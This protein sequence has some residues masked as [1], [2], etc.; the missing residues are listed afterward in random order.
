[1]RGPE[2]HLSSTEDATRTVSSGRRA[3][4]RGMK[5]VSC[6]I[7]MLHILVISPLAGAAETANCHVGIYRLSDGT[8]VDIGHSD[9]D[10]LR[11]RRFDGATGHLTRV[12]DGPWKSTL[13][14]TAR[15]DDKGV[16]LSGC[17]EGRISFEGLQGHRLGLD[18]RETTFTSHGVTLAGRLLLPKGATTVPIVVLVHGAEHESARDFNPLQ[19]ILPAEGVGS[20][21]YDKRGTGASGGDYSQDFNLLA[22][23][24]VAA[25]REA[26]RLAGSR[27]GRI[28][29]QGGS[30]A[31][32]VIPIAVNRERVDFAIVCFGLAV[33]VIDE[34]QQEVQIEMRE[35]GHSP[36]E[37]A[38]ALQVASAAETVIASGFTRGFREFDAIR[39]LYKDAPWYKD[40]HGNYTYMLLPYSEAELR[41]MAPKFAW[42]TPFYYDPM[43]A[44]R[45]DTTSQLWI[46]G[47]E[48]YEAPSL[49]T[50]YRIKSLIADGRPFTLA[51]YPGAEHGMTLFETDPA[52]GERLS[53]RYAPR[54]FA[55]IRDYARN[56]RLHGAYG[57]AE[58]TRPRG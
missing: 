57:D 26:K 2:P 34:D 44:L 23:D 4:A 56:G 58:L 33:S 32:W 18:V 8:T 54:Y 53:T 40:L 30:Q 45:S 24:L 41:A 51:V 28:G 9:D 22:D 16:G 19:R 13:G 37:V 39:A 25:M 52:S 35:K 15:P 47:T 17:A 42:G 12:G 6:S 3:R 43:P 11:W 36:M 50:S 46:L 27:A 29:Y 7:A 38:S 14:W 20:F 48:D 49:E 21:V 1:M 10:T 55:M 5:W 31:G